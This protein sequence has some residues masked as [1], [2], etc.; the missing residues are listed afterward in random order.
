[1]PGAVVGLGRWAARLELE[2][3]VRAGRSRLVVC[4][5]SGP[6]LVQRVFHPEPNGTA[7]LYLL[8]PPGGIAGGDRLEIAIRVHAGA[9]ALVTTPA[10]AKLYR[11]TGAG[12]EQRT[13]L[14]VAADATLEWLPQESIV[15]DGARAH[16][17][18]AVHLERGARFAG[19]EIACLGRTGA[20]ETFKTGHWMQRLAIH[21][22]GQ[23]LLVE[24]L[25]ARAGDAVLTRAWGLGGHPV[26]GTLLLVTGPCGT[27]PGELVS[28]IRSRLSH[29]PA[30]RPG[31]LFAA[32]ALD[33][34]IVCRYLGSSAPRARA[35]FA[36]A[37]DLFRRTALGTAAVPPRIWAT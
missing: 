5:H 19:W 32:S 22:C 21:Q 29:D 16:T 31:E 13:E 10:A 25:A 23:P 8:H 18:T 9:R 26:T 30:Q 7:H 15:F 17:A 2:I 36:A 28:A 37:W 33:G 4:R 6:L 34:V 35:C 11:C 20:G 24:R 1:V 14:H 27:A 3:A 12:S